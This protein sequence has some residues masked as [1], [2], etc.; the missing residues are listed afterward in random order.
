MID[1]PIEAG[2]QITAFID[3]SNA[4]STDSGGEQHRDDWFDFRIEHKTTAAV[5]AETNDYLT[6]VLEA[7]AE[8]S[9][10]RTASPLYPS[11]RR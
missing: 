7:A 4:V 3:A 1:Y 8:I 2:N 5:G 11:T 10:P 9:W 6:P